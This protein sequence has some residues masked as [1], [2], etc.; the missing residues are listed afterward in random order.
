MADSNIQSTNRLAVILGLAMALG[1][2]TALSFG[3][4][5]ASEE[6]LAR[7][8]AAVINAKPT[9]VFA[10]YVPNG[11]PSYAADKSVGDIVHGA[12]VF[13]S[14]E[15]ALQQAGADAILK[16]GG[17]WTV[18][19][20]SEDAFNALSPEER[21]A[22]MNDQDKLAGLVSRHIVPG[23]WVSTDLQR[24]SELKT[25]SG[26]AIKAGPQAMIN[27]NIGVGGA[28]VIQGNLQAANGVVHV[29][30]RMLN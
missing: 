13:R 9:D 2:L 3:S 14:F 7:A 17:T 4:K 11:V 27:G 6:T 25:L 15:Q 21:A 1:P 29:V 19:A 30:D 8:N 24:V 16:S 28:T 26:D 20:P 18:F 10:P 23:R 5:Y 22:L 12:A